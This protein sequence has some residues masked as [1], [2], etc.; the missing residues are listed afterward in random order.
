MLIWAK[1]RDEIDGT[2]VYVSKAMWNQ[3]VQ[4]V[5]QASSHK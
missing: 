3:M 4:D 5:K 2:W 1:H